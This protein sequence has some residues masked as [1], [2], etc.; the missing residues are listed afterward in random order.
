M[1]PYYTYIIHSQDLNL[2]Y[3]GYS[4]DPYHRL[5][6][7]NNNESRYTANK[8]PW[9][10]IFIQAHDSKAEAIIA[11]KKLKKAGSQYLQKLILSN[12]NR[13]NQELG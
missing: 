4:K 13:L 2:Y 12:K 7:H 6:Q 11:E 10:L 8:G 3:K 5:I 1:I 9:K